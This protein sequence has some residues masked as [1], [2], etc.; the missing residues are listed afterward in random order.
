VLSGLAKLLKHLALV[1]VDAQKK[2]PLGVRKYLSAYLQLFF[3][4]LET[5]T[6]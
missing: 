2:S 5:A 6:R 4:E 1:M 3:D